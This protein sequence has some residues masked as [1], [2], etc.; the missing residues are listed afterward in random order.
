M[1]DKLSPKTAIF[2]AIVFL[3]P[4]LTYGMDLFLQWLSTRGIYVPIPF[5]SSSLLRVLTEL[6]LYM[7]L[8][9]GLNIVAGQLRR[10]DVGFAAFYLVGGYTAGLLMTKLG[11]NYWIVLVLA[12][13]HGALWGLLRTALT[14]WLR[15]IYFAIATFGLAGLLYVAV[16][17]GGMSI[18]APDGTVY[19]IPAPTIFG[20]ELYYNWQH[21]YHILCLL[22]FAVFIV[23]RLHNSRFVLGDSRERSDAAENEEP[24]PRQSCY[25]VVFAISAAIGA[26]GGAFFAQFRANIN[27]DAFAPWESILVLCMVVVGGLGS[28]RGALL[29]A[30]VV[31]LANEVLRLLLPI[32]FSSLRYLIFGALAILVMRCCPAGV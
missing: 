14:L 24:Q 5:G 16:K 4:L 1:R 6:Y 13:M 32:Q 12:A 17:H 30:G 22:V 26:V 18:G 7:L 29:G 23:Y 9:V 8:A 15:G 21:Y 27:S 11:W 28:I 10:P 3:L 31:G 2:V 19:G 20:Y 25:F